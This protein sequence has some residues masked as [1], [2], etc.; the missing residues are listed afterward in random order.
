V[1]AL[2][3]S[4]EMKTSIHVLTLAVLVANCRPKP[5][6]E[7]SLPNRITGADAI[8][9]TTQRPTRTV[10]SSVDLEFSYR[11]TISHGYFTADPDKDL[12]FLEVAIEY[13]TS[14]GIGVSMMK[15]FAL[16]D[17]PKDIL[18]RRADQIV[19]Q[20]ADSIIFDLGTVTVTADKPWNR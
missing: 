7:L 20:T 4:E 11:A 15:A 9:F 3:V 18:D 5:P 17:L 13:P 12:D 6:E 16:K 14:R 8:E 10:V 19:S 1:R 2:Y